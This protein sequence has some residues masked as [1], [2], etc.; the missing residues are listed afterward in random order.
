MRTVLRRWERNGACSSLLF[1]RARWKFTPRRM[2]WVHPAHDWLISDGWSHHWLNAPS[3]WAR[4]HAYLAP[5]SWLVRCFK[6]LHWRIRLLS[7]PSHHLMSDVA[8][9]T[10]T[11]VSVSRSLSKWKLCSFFFDFQRRISQE[12][13]KVRG[14]V[15]LSRLFVSAFYPT[16]KWYQITLKKKRD[17]VKT[18]RPLLLS[19]F[20]T[21]NKTCSCL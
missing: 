9:Y 2:L 12:E 7:S 16:E 21:E 19:I 1:S 10:L 15:H 13:K 17:A 5:R 18:L 8:N 14:H 20:N 6:A 11:T 3:V 4:R